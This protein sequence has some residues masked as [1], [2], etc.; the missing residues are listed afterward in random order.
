LT[1]RLTVGV[2]TYGNGPRRSHRSDADMES[3]LAA[4]S[5]KWEPADIQLVGAK[6]ERYPDYHPTIDEQIADLRDNYLP[7]AP[8][9]IVLFYLP[10]PSV[11]GDPVNGLNPARSRIVF[12]GDTVKLA[13]AEPPP[14]PMTRTTGNTLEV[15]ARVCAHEIGHILLGP[16][17]STDP[18][19]LM[20][21]G[22][23]GDM[24][25]NVDKSM[26]N[27]RAEAI[28]IDRKT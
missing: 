14:T 21:Q 7:S 13:V 16:S 5:L 11:N 2:F 22:S 3:I 4:A 20:F 12:L 28:I 17:H 1:A 15:A 19:N 10:R 18:M 8:F 27:A 6:V 26:A 24:L 25:T 23:T 9:D